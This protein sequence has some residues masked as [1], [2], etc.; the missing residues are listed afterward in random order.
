MIDQDGYGGNL[1]P[2][3]H[4]P[5]DEDTIRRKTAEYNRLSGESN[6]AEKLVCK[7][8]KA[9]LGGAKTAQLDAC[10]SALVALDR[11]ASKLRQKSVRILNPKS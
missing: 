4:C 10:R 5:R 7:Y 9:R 3:G 11:L 2:K 8:R 6:D 1:S